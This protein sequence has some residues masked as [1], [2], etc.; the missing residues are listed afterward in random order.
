[1]LKN[2]ATMFWCCDN[3]NQD[4]SSWDVSSVKTMEMMFCDCESLTINPGWVINRGTNTNSM[5][6]NTPLKNVKLVR[7]SY[8]LKT[9]NKDSKNLVDYYNEKLE[10]RRGKKTPTNIS[11]LPEELIDKTLE[12]FDPRGYTPTVK[13]RKAP[14]KESLLLSPG[15]GYAGGKKKKRTQKRN[16]RKF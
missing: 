3:F 12:Y 8:N 11:A 14:P 16:N 6:D 2:M 15:G 7:S 4:L 10:Q 1:M 13:S 9:A 5:F